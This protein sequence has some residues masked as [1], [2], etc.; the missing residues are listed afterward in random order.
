MRYLVI[1]AILL[2]IS[3]VLYGAEMSVGL[4]YCAILNHPTNQSAESMVAIYFDIPDSLL[5]K[6]IIYSELNFPFS[7]QGLNDSSLYEFTVFPA[8]SEWTEQTIDYEGAVELA[9]SL[10]AGAYTIK[11]TDMSQFHIAITSFVSEV[12][13]SERDNFG[14]IVL[15]D[16][17]GNNYLRLPSNMGTAIRNAATVRIVFK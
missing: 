10:I 14:L 17:L 12:A 11:L 3:P 4:G 13:N 9:D 6:K 2:A 15:A 7:L 1:I 8:I 16:L 5:G